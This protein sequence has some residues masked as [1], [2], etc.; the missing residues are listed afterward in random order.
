MEGGTSYE[1]ENGTSRHA[2]KSYVSWDLLIYFRHSLLL[3]PW[4]LAWLTG[5]L[6]LFIMAYDLKIWG[7]VG[8]SYLKR[9]LADGLS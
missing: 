1:E 9:Q 6:E 4:L 3:L 7:V 8:V 2:D 5:V